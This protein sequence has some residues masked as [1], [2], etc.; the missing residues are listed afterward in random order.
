[1]QIQKNAFGEDYPNLATGL[2]NLGLVYYEQ[3]K[4]ELAE[5]HYLKAM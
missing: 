2:T 5:Q 1:M 4:L 3:G